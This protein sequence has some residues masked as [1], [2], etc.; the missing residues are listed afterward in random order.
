MGTKQSKPKPKVESAIQVKDSKKFTVALIAALDQEMWSTAKLL[1]DTQDIDYDYIYDYRGGG[2]V[3]IT[4][5]IER[6]CKD[7][8]DIVMTIIQLCSIQTINAGFYHTVDNIVMYSLKRK[9]IP[10]EVIK[11]IIDR[12][13]DIKYKNDKF[14]NALDVAIACSNEEIALAII[15]KFTEEKSR[16]VTICLRE[17]LPVCIIATVCIL[18]FCKFEY[19]GYHNYQGRCII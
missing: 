11:Y 9:L 12:G 14:E 15:S 8:H 18:A 3:V 5:A 13:I 19:P 10:N 7:S 4:K 1:V 17:V 6:Y 16:E 2:V